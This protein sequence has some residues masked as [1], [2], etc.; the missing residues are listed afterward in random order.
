MARLERSQRLAVLRAIQDLQVTPR[1]LRGLDPDGPSG[2]KSWT[3]GDWTAWAAGYLIAEGLVSDP[4]DDVLTPKLLL[5][6]IRKFYEARH[7]QSFPWEAGAVGAA[8]LRLLRT[9]G[10]W[11][12][13]K[14]WVER[15]LLPDGEHDVWLRLNRVLAAVAEATAT[16][17]AREFREALGLTLFAGSLLHL[18]PFGGT[19]QYKRNSIQTYFEPEGFPTAD[20]WEPIYASIEASL[21]AQLN[22][23]IASYL[24][25]VR[26]RHVDGK[27]VPPPGAGSD[28]RPLGSNALRTV[29]RDIHEEMDDYI[30]WSKETKIRPLRVEFG[31]T[32]WHRIQGFCNRLGKDAAFRQRALSTETNWV[33]D[34][35]PP[36]Q[37]GRVPS[38]VAVHA[39]LTGGRGNDSYL[40]LVQ[41]PQQ[42]HYFPL[43]WEGTMAENHMGPRKVTRDGRDEISCGDVDL[44]DCLLRGIEEEFGLLEEDLSY[45]VLT[46]F[47]VEAPFASV[48]AMYRVHTPLAF[49][50]LKYRMRN[51]RNPND[52]E[53]S[54][55]PLE[56]N[57]VAR[58]PLTAENLARLVLAPAYA[59]RQQ[60]RARFEARSNVAEGRDFFVVGSR[61][62][63]MGFHPATSARL[64]QLML[65]DRRRF[66]P[67]R[68]VS[69]FEAALSELTIPVV[70][71]EAKEAVPR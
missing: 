7:R 44:H 56:A 9:Y 43:H 67:E 8:K 34:A 54:A 26:E 18:A 41:R 6:V 70:S 30:G 5:P 42:V 58:E 55:V 52:A 14:S 36:A 12:G 66:P 25:T 57:V 3:A 45:V 21:D 1:D 62:G 19:Y 38:F 47:F 50:T 4:D 27:L 48:V 29:I 59:E 16:T 35:L 68:V 64:L 22:A 37:S 69:A 51:R 65:S 24:D 63:A 10:S 15:F 61:T 11:E 53:K 40:V 31:V 23:E 71:N 2:A 17:E 60:E 33:R 46:G 20:S 39:A 49:E 13:V 32:D 28:W